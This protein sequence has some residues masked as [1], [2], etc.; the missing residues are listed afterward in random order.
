MRE[1]LHEGLSCSEKLR[2][3]FRAVSFFMDKMNQNPVQFLWM[4][5]NKWGGA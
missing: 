1:H 4:R 3:R 5:Y 2:K